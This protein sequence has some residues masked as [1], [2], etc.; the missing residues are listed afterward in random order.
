MPLPNVSQIR[1]N[2]II[3]CLKATLNTLEV[4]ARSL[5]TPFLQAISSTLNSLLIAVQTV[6]KK[7]EQ[8][9]SM[10]EQVHG[11]LSAIIHLHINTDGPSTRF[12]LSLK[13]NRKKA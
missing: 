12:T 9:A 1:F 13:L 4:I 6:Q 3:T 2:N 7:T 10:L 11:L 8:C 5:Q